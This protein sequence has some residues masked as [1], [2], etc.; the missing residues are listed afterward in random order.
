MA[1][2]MYRLSGYAFAERSLPWLGL[3]SIA[4]RLPKKQPMLLKM[5]KKI[6]TWR[7]L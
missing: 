5:K 3:N 7:M 2:L 6:V 4:A 1:K